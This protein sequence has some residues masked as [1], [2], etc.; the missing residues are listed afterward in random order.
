MSSTR[1]AGARETNHAAIIEVL[2]SRGPTTRPEL[3]RATGLGRKIISERVQELLNVGLVSEG[4]FAPSTGGRMARKIDF[5]ADRGVVAV[6]E[7]NV[8]HATVGIADLAGR[9]LA[10]RQVEVDVRDGPAIAVAALASAISALAS[11]SGWSLD[12]VWGVG[13][14]VLAPVDRSQG[15]VV[16]GHLFTRTTMAGWDGFR[17]RDRLQEQLGRPVWVDNEVNLMALGELR[18]GRARGQSDVVFVKLGPS[19]GGGLVIG[20]RLQHGKAS[21]GEIGHLV[22]PHEEPRPCWCGGRGCL[23]TF[24]NDASVLAEAGGRYSSLAGLLQSA[25]GDGHAVEVL[26]RAG[27]RTGAVLANVVTLLDPSLLLLGGTLVDHGEIVLDA[28]RA[29]VST[30]GMPYA[31]ERLRIEHSPL[32]DRAGLVGAAAMAVDALF[33]PSVLGLWLAEGSPVRHLEAL[34]SV[35]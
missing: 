16:P 24:I 3:E 6:A 8:Y 32:S 10:L 12:A 34:V 20:G 1:L 29:V 2:R 22:V 4:D 30:E 14:G 19:V 15:T 21:A 26:R 11:E 27:V 13:V 33:E 17:V 7:M 25:A 35:P 23:A 28:I 18:S 31:A 9:T 5:R